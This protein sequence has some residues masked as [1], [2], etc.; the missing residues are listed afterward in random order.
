MSGWAAGGVCHDTV[1]DAL[2]AHA[3]VRGAWVTPWVSGGYAAHEY[4][5]LEGD[6]DEPSLQLL[7]R[8]WDAQG[9]EAGWQYQASPSDLPSCYTD[10][11][12]LVDGVMVG[13][14]VVGCVVAGWCV[15][16][17]RRALA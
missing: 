5:A 17:I 7:T 10:A 8:W 4:V 3:A 12:L 16:A 1:L 6:G 11:E 13:W 2:R 14:L 15:R 9:Q